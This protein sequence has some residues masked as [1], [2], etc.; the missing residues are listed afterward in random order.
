MLRKTKIGLISSK[1]GHLFQLLQLKKLLKKYNRFWVTFTG[2]DS[3]F[4]LK[5]ESLYQAFYPES[6]NFPNAVRNFFLAIKILKKERPDFLISCGAGI[7]VPFFIVGKL[8]FKIKLIYIEP[9]DFISY[10]SLTGRIMYNFVNLFLVQHKSQ[11]K[12]FPKAS[13]WGSLL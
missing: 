11:K 13:H 8:I 9:Y 2:Q 6:R 7:S 1:G 3:S 10:P 5:N 4:Y 12:W